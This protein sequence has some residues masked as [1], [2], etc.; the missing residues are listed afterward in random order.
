MAREFDG[1]EVWRAIADSPDIFTALRAD[2]ATSARTTLVKYLKTKALRIQHLRAA[3]K[4]LG[5]DLFRLLVDGMKDAEM[6]ALVA[7][8]DRHHPDMKASDPAWR[9]QHFLSLVKGDVEPAERP[10]KVAKTKKASPKPKREEE[11]GEWFTSAGA[12]RK[13]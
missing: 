11:D 7:R 12:V 5:K 9:R 1:F 10:A 6:K 13:R 4:A 8:L 3:R 2:A